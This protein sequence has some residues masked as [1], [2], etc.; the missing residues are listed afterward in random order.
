MCARPTTTANAPRLRPPTPAPAPPTPAPRTLCTD[1]RSQGPRSR[2]LHGHLQHGDGLDDLLFGADWYFSASATTGRAYLV[3]GSSLGIDSTI[4]IEDADMT[5][6]TLDA[7]HLGQ[8]VAAAGDVNG[9]GLAD[10]LAPSSSTN[11][12][13][14]D[15][16]RSMASSLPFTRSLAIEV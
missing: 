11:C 8:Q 9:D 10:I 2:C 14:L 7:V 15:F 4:N 1:C 13:T 6:Y 16:G 3:L 5:F 12:N